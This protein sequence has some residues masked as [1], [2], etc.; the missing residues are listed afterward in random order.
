MTNP[1]NDADQDDTTVFFDCCVSEEEYTTIVPE[2]MDL[3][4]GTVLL[5][6]VHEV[7]KQ[8]GLY[9]RS[10]KSYTSLAQCFTSFIQQY[11]TASPSSSTDEEAATGWGGTQQEDT[12]KKKKKNPK[13]E[14]ETD[15]TQNYKIVFRS[16][17]GD[18]HPRYKITG[19]APVYWSIATL[20]KFGLGR[21]STGPPRIESVTAVN[22][23]DDPTVCPVVLF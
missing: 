14:E 17:A 13:K 15:E 8:T 5:Q 22:L 18:D 11:E 3:E 10:C 1:S 9:H 7:R 2:D 16:V 4:D 20:T 21:F 6:L 23:L 12:S 19:I